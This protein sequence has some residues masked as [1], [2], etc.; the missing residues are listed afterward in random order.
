M[1]LSIFSRFEIAVYKA[2][3]LSSLYS[4]FG[5]DEGFLNSKF[6]R[7][8]NFRF[9][10]FRKSCMATF[11]ATLYIQEENFDSPLNEG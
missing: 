4:F 1:A 7:N 11:K 6:Y 2:S 5:G 8:K 10:S 3:I 9:F